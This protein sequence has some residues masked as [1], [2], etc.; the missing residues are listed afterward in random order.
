MAPKL[1]YFLIHPGPFDKT[2]V[3]LAAQIISASVAAGMPIAL[4]CRLLSMLSIASQKTICFI[5]DMD[6]LFDI[7]N[8]RK[9]P[10]SK[11]F[12]T[13]FNNASLQLGSSNKNY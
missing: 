11:I 2:K 13:P 1:T 5:N 9:T 3:T 4:N 7:F 12:N 6:K 8:S 10:N